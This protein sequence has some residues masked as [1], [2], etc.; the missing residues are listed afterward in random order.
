MAISKKTSK[1]KVKS[2]AKK[3]QKKQSKNPLVK[4]ELLED[5]L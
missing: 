5:I 1:A 4:E 3:L 2:K